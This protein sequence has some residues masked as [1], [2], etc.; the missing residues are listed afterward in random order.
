PTEQCE[1]TVCFTCMS[2]LNFTDTCPACAGCTTFSGSLCA[3]TPTP[4]V[5][6]ARFRKLRR[7]S[8]PGIGERGISEAEVGLPPDFLVSNMRCLLTDGRRNDSTYECAPFRDT[9]RAQ[10]RVLRRERQAWQP[11]ALKIFSPAGQVRW[12]RPQW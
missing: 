11:A 2:E 10:R 6:P 12:P 7:S 9:C 5:R 4:A 3:S 8:V 1:Q